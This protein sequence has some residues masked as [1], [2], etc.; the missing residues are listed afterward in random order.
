MIRSALP[1]ALCRRNWPEWEQKE[2]D[3]RSRTAHP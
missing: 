1:S 2:M 3:R